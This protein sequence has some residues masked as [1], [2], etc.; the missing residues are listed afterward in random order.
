[1]LLTCCCVLTSAPYVARPPPRHAHSCV[2]TVVYGNVL[3]GPA[4][5]GGQSVYYT[6]V[7][8]TGAW[9]NVRLARRGAVG[10]SWLAGMLRNGQALRR[11]CLQTCMLAACHTLGAAWLLCTSL[12]LI[13]GGWW[14]GTHA[15][16]RRG[17]LRQVSV[18]RSLS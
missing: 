2:P 16:A 15:E 14:P 7:N 5:Y 6:P 11:L 1:M 12:H 10:T 17:L 3:G 18:H 9:V 8:Y 4:A 13:L